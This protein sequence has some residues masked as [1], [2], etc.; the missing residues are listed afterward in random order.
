MP[1]GLLHQTV[2]VQPFHQK[3]PKYKYPVQSNMT[4]IIQCWVFPPGSI[5]AYSIDRQALWGNNLIYPKRVAGQRWFKQYMQMSH[6]NA[7]TAMPA[8]FA[9]DG[10][11]HKRPKDIRTHTWP[12][13]NWTFLI[14]FAQ[15]LCIKLHFFL[16]GR[17]KQVGTGVLCK[18]SLLCS[19]YYLC[20]LSNNTSLFKLMNICMQLHKSLQC[21]CRTTYFTSSG[22]CLPYC[23]MYTCHC[24]SSRGMGFIEGPIECHYSLQY[25]AYM[26]KSM[27]EIV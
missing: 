7:I 22:Y 2:H 1:G 3:L 10:K 19:L 27:H 17:I 8:Q 9:I 24:R 18:Q 12:V 15:H 23:C 21:F 16:W 6:L 11:W 14:H 5:E 26:Y 25:S 20:L 4:Q 13:G